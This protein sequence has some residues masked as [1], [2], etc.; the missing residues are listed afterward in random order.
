MAKIPKQYKGYKFSVD[1][2]QKWYATTD[3]KKHKVTIN[4]RKSLHAGGVE[5][6]RDTIRHEKA[7]IDN[8]EATEKEVDKK[9]KEDSLRETMFKGLI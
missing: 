9:H 7:H 1:N 4:V 8:P 5:E 2:K 6:L 3:D